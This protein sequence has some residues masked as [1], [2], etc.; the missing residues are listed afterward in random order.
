M[1]SGFRIDIASSDEK[2]LVTAYDALALVASDEGCLDE[3]AFAAVSRVCSSCG[4]LATTRCGGCQ[5]APSTTSAECLINGAWYCGKACQTNHWR[6]H[7]QVCKRLQQRIQIHHAAQL[8]KEIWLVFRRWTWHEDVRTVKRYGSDIKLHIGNMEKHFRK[9][10]LYPFKCTPGLGL[11]IVD[12]CLIYNM[13]QDALVWL[14]PIME[15]LLQGMSLIPAAET[16]THNLCRS[17]YANRG[18]PDEH[19]KPTSP[20]VTR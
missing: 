5:N 7:K 11:D 17:R 13:C 4:S 15:A 12:A 18:V 8:V 16:L 20:H 2:D 1:S 3:D 9:R 19:Q 14:R 10:H 6:K